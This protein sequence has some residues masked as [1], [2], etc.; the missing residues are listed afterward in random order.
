MF[1][2]V[3]LKTKK[4]VHMKGKKVLLATLCAAVAVGCC[5]M[6]AGCGSKLD[7]SAVTGEVISVDMDNQ[8]AVLKITN[9]SEQNISLPDQ[10]N[11]VLTLL[12]EDGVELATDDMVYLDAV[13]LP[14]QSEVYTLANFSIYDLEDDSAVKGGSVAMNLN[15]ATALEGDGFTEPCVEADVSSKV[16]KDGFTVKFDLKYTGE[17]EAVTG[18]REIFLG[19]DANDACVFCGAGTD[20]FGDDTLCN[21]E[22]TYGMLKG[23]DHVESHFYPII[24]RED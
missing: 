17:N 14:A 11:A 4:G 5:L 13:I 16:L 19:F 24:I 18:Y 2:G 3:E 6:V 23:I 10:G 21:A 9:A 20:E 12:G 22:V 1:C 15:G 8:Q 7:E